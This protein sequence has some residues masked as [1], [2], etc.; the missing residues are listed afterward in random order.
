MFHRFIY[1]WIR[2]YWFTDS[3]RMHDNNGPLSEISREKSVKF[4]VNHKYSKRIVS[5]NKR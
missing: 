2:G 5:R 3:D 4:D 1:D